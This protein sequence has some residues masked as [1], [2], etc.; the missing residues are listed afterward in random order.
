MS[1]NNEK[2]VR[3]LAE[4]LAAVR[5]RVES[6][7][8]RT[9]RNPGEIRLMAV[10]KNHGPEIVDA[11]AAAG[12]DL[13]GENRVQEATGKQSQVRASLAWELIG[14]LQSNKARLAVA[15]FDRIQTVDREKIARALGRA[16]EEI[17]RPAVPVLLQ[18]NIGE[19]P[20]KAGVSPEGAE[21]LIDQIRSVERL[22]LQG[23]M[24]IPPFSEDPAVARRCFAAL[25]VLR[26]QL[27]ANTG[28]SLHELS[29]GMSGDFDIAVEEGA[30]LIRVGTIL[31]GER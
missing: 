20:R 24:T 14:P 6:A 15:H 17:N 4:R 18:V 2:S 1:E 16:A 27:V 8:A 22:D 9:G 26:D 12:I 31:F 11:A 21:A 25:R 28:L 10:T 13:V 5:S 29:M 30:T 7:S 3:V 19:D 23:L